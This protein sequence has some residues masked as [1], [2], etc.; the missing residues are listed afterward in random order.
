MS[1]KPNVNI[2]KIVFGTLALL[3]CLFVI[4]VLFIK[5]D[6]SAA[7]Q[8]TDNIL[9]PIFGNHSVV[10]VEKM[11]YNTSDK[12]TQ[13]TDKNATGPEFTENDQAAPA[14]GDLNLNPMAVNQKLTPLKN[15]GVWLWKK[16]NIFPNQ[17]VLAYTFVRPD[18]DR[19]YA[20]VTLIQADIGPLLLGDV[21]GTKQPGGPIGNKGPGIIPTNIIQNGRLVAAFD[22]GFQYRDGRYGMIVNG[23][24]YVP[25]KNNLGTLVGYTNGSIK[26]V[27]Y[28]GQD[29]GPG[30]SYIRQNCPILIEDGN[31]AVLNPQNHVL[32][33][34]TDTTDIYTW[35]SG[36][37][38]TKE[39]NLIYAVGNNINPTTL[40]VALKMGGAVNAIQLDINPFWVRF[41][42]FDYLG[43][44]NYT[45]TALM[46]GVYNGA[47]QFLGGYEK[48]FFFLYKK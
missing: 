11:Y 42:I 1:K 5:F 17:D 37:G 10:F 7:A 38:I 2:K 31:F 9:R 24:I 44:G 47:K 14:S 30:V 6:T 20:D 36:V 3:F 43:S 40:A 25:L 41:S 28:T 26:I 18:P 12:F 29:L 46:K 34:R 19:P 15:E 21:A 32:W 39:G 27:N 4:L 8:F 16:L 13:L 33:G 35:R 45:S 22:G 23:K 48:D